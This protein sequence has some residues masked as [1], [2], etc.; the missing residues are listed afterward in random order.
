MKSIFLSLSC[1]GV[2]EMNRTY[3]FLELEGDASDWALLNSL[4]KMS[5]E[6]YTIGYDYSHC[7]KDQD[8]SARGQK[9]QNTNLAS[10]THAAR[11]LRDNGG[12]YIEARQ[13]KI[14]LAKPRGNNHRNT[15]NLRLVKSKPFLA[16][17][18]D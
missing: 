6:T 10:Q 18:F 9:K 17:E 7:S 3:L 8:L 11:T 4:H 5:G 13:L 16:A 1:L 12:C 2:S 14:V 15:L